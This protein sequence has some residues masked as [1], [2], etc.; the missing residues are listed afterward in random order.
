MPYTLHPHADC[1]RFDEAVELL[2]NRM[3]D[4]DAYGVATIELGQLPLPHFK[5]AT[6]V[7]LIGPSDQHENGHCIGLS[8]ARRFR[9]NTGKVDGDCCYSRA[10]RNDP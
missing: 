2:L 6:L 9:H 5:I 1:T 3:P 7:V 10:P 4:F 8:S